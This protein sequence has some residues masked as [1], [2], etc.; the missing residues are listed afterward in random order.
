MLEQVNSGMIILQ[1]QENSRTNGLE[2]RVIELSRPV[3]QVC[4]KLNDVQL[5]A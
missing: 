3:F 4:W 1:L 2:T 5:K